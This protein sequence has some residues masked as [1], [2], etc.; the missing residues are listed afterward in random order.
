MGER[1]SCWTGRAHKP[2]CKVPLL[3]QLLP[4]S[5]DRKTPL[6]LIHAYAIVKKAAALSNAELGV[7]PGSKAD[8]IIT[9]CDEIACGKLDAEFPLDALQGGAGTSTNMNLNEV[10]AN[11]ALEILGRSKGDYA[12]ISPLA[13]INLHQSTNDT[14]PTALKVAAFG[15]LKNLSDAVAL[16]QGTLQ[17]L[18][19]AFEPIVIIGR[20]ELQE[21][22]PMTLGGQ[23]STFAEA[24]GR[25]RWRTNKSQERIRQVNLGG[26]ALGTG[27]CAARDYIFLVVE[28]LRL[29]TGYGLAPAENRMDQTANQDAFTE[30]SGILKAHAA[31]LMKISGDL[32]LLA[33]FEI[34]ELPKVQTGSS[35][36]P[37][38]TNPVILE[39][40]IQA[41][42]TVIANDGL[43]TAAA[44][45][46]TLQI[47]EFLPLI[48][49]SLLE[50]LDLLIGTNRMLSSHI[51]GIR[52]NEKK[53]AE[54]LSRSKGIAAAFIPL[55]GYE[56]IESLLREFETT[57]REDIRNFF[58]EKFGAA[59]VAKT[60]SA[61][62]LLK[63]GYL[64]EPNA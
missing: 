50:N 26:T 20:T 6:S 38:K 40:A 35:I 2:V 3:V 58:E 64:R 59:V 51:A 46:G 11:R 37:G 60:L 33:A 7:L 15:K 31:N 63:L 8:A 4:E 54:A 29:L 61:Q 18:E 42:M 36:M 17:G 34:I 39:A 5:T 19:K 47:N 32:R 43:L 52:A 48:A 9:A 22:V 62:N 21:A 45:R 56:K 27:L 44:S 25:D 57:G 30:V 55:A 10:I 1:T 14:Y 41:G 28:K 12:F 13:H 53:C 24:I 16:L 23:F 49:V